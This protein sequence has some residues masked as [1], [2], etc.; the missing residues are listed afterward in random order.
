[1]NN[2]NVDSTVLLVR[3]PSFPMGTLPMGVCVPLDVCSVYRT[4]QLL[5]PPVPTVL[6]GPV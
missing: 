3:I 6:K 1:M 4:Y 2:I 5:V